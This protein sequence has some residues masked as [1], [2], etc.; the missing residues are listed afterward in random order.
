MKTQKTVLAASVVALGLLSHPLLSQAFDG[1]GFHR[2]GHHCARS[3][4]A[5]QGP[6]WGRLA[7]RLHLT[8][9]QRQS[10]NTI[11]DKYRPALRDLRQ[12]LSDKRTALKT[13]DAT[14]AKLPE[15]AAAQGKAISDMIVM[16]KQMRS[17]M[18]KV[19][20]DEQRQTLGKMLE[21]RRL[22]RQRHEGMRQG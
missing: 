16:R 21:Q 3:G 13:M 1:E 5:M 19:L 7:D 15:L 12:S 10:M 4:D 11:E 6:G 9:E 17:E 8:K 18:D 2:S 14:D 20:T 22:H